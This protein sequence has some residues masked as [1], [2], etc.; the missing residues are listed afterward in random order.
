MR[1]LLFTLVASSGASFDRP[2]T[3]GISV[4][5]A[6]STDSSLRSIAQAARVLDIVAGKLSRAGT[7]FSVGA[8]ATQLFSDVTNQFYTTTTGFYPFIA[9]F[10]GVWVAHG[11]NAA[12]VGRDM[13]TV[14]GSNPALRPYVNGTILN[15]AFVSAATNGGGAVKYAWTNG[16][17]GEATKVSLIAGV[18]SGGVS[19][20]IGVGWNDMMVNTR[21]GLSNSDTTCTI[22]ACAPCDASYNAPCAVDN[23]L[24]LLGHALS[25]AYTS[26]DLNAAMTSI[27]TDSAYKIEAGFYAFVYTLS[28]TCLAHGAN[29]LFVGRT[30][31]DIIAGSAALTSNGVSG[32][33]LNLQF[34]QT[35]QSGGGWVSYLWYS[36]SLGVFGKQ[37]Y[38][39]P[40]TVGGVACYMGVGYS[41]T[42]DPSYVPSTGPGAAGET[43][44]ESLMSIG[45]A[46]LVLLILIFLL[47]LG[48]IPVVVGSRRPVANGLMREV[49]LTSDDR[50]ASGVQST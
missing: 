14:I 19:Y 34:N 24:S 35:A 1:H 7:G 5:K 15:R 47:L 28:G 30:L 44:T 2:L 16:M 12:L 42:V 8:T 39:V 11:A 48:Y 10:D 49:Q 23:T 18:A 26:A 3:L 4:A 27:S 17:S 46:S 50:K 6:R 37:A 38:I 45:V 29:S 21:R 9:T 22:D 41:D 36:A 13:E 31:Q 25:L 33:A 43:S 32:S 40:L 20:Y